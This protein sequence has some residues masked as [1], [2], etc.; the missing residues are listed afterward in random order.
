ML[1]QTCNNNLSWYTS[2]Y[3]VSN[4]NEYIFKPGVAVHTCNSCTQEFEEN[5]E[6]EGI[7]ITRPCLENSVNQTIEL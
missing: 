6:L 7:Y 5:F 2:H 4:I 3:F 1:M